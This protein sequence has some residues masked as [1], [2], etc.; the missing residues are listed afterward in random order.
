M[1]LDSKHVFSNESERANE[2]LYGDFKMKKSFGL[3]GFYTTITQ[4]FKSLKTARFQS[5]WSGNS[6][7]DSLL[8]MNENEEEHCCVK[9]C[10]IR[11]AILGY[12]DEH[13]YTNSLLKVN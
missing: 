2:K 8:K 13:V 6:G 12:P 1:A 7:S 3:H 4:H 10:K 11:N 9:T 5:T